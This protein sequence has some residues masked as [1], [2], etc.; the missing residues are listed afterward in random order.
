MTPTSDNQDQLETLRGMVGDLDLTPEDL[1]MVLSS[2][3]SLKR[4]KKEEEGPKEN[5]VFGDKIFLWEN[6]TDSFIYRDNRTKGKNFYLRIYCKETKKVFSKSLRTPSKEEGIVLGRQLYQE[7][8]GKLIRGEKTKSLTTEEL[9]NIYLEREERK[10]SPIPK[11]GITL[12]SFR[13]KRSYL[14]VWKKFISEEKKMSKTPIEKIPPDTTRDFGYWIQNQEKRSSHQK[15]GY[16]TDYINSVTSEVLK[17]YR[18]VGVR[19]K[20]ISQNHIPEIDFLKGQ[21]S[22]QSK[23]DIFS[24]DEYLKFVRY[25]RTNKYLKPEGSSELERGRRSIYREFIGISYNTGMR[26]MELLKLKW[27]DISINITDTKENQK[28]YRII[29]VRSENSKTGRMRSVNGPVGR[30]FER[31]KKTYEKLGFECGPDTF[32]FRNTHPRMKGENVPYKKSMFSKRLVDLLME[33]G[34]KEDLDKSG[35]HITLYS[36]R[37]FYTTMRLQ[38]GLDIHLLSKQLGTST[39]YID[40]TYSHIQVETNTERITQG[41]TLLKT[42]EE[43]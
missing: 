12:T 25:L 19:D 28:I 9:I 42:L 37:H 31:L 21:P 27:G 1:L 13:R 8:Y 16:S 10:I 15:T 40:Q 39:N 2:V 4:K 3:V 30:R 29:K 11:T 7:M 24:V 34:L 5:K 18:E 43:E 32:V 38:N 26:P 14:K 17:M 22:N 23:R 35:K 41:M 36:S 33:S 6:S 20:F